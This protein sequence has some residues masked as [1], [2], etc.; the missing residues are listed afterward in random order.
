MGFSFYRPVSVDS[1]VARCNHTDFVVCFRFTLSYL[2]TVANGGSVQNASGYDIVFATDSAG[3]SILPFDRDYYDPSTGECVFWIKLPTTDQVFYLCYGNSGISA[4]QQNKATCWSDYL[5]V[6]HLSDGT[7]LSGSDAVSASHDLTNH[8]ALA[9]TGLNDGGANFPS[10]ADA[11]MESSS[12][13]FNDLTVNAPVTFSFWFKSP[14]TS[15]PSS[16]TILTVNDG[17]TDAGKGFQIY[18]NG[19][20]LGFEVLSP[21][22]GS[23]TVGYWYIPL[24]DTNWHHVSITYTG[25]VAGLVTPGSARI[26]LD[27]RPL[28]T[29][30]AFAYGG[31]QVSDAGYA[32]QF[33]GDPNY[34]GASG[35]LDAIIDEL[36][37]RQFD[38]DAEWALDHYNSGNDP[39]TFL[40]IG[41][42]NG[43][44]PS[45]PTLLDVRSVIPAIG[46]HGYGSYSA[47]H[48]LTFE[49]SNGDVFRL[50]FD[51]GASLRYKIVKLS[52]SRWIEMDGAYNTDQGPN[53]SVVMVSDKLY[54][55]S[56]KSSGSTLY[57]DVFDTTAETFDSK[58]NNSGITVTPFPNFPSSSYKTQSGSQLGKSIYEVAADSSG[59][60]HLT[61]VLF[62]TVN[63]QVFSRIWYTKYDHST[64]STPIELSG[65]SGAY[66]YWPQQMIEAGGTMRLFFLR[67]GWTAGSPTQYNGGYT[68]I[69]AGGAPLDSFRLQASSPGWTAGQFSSYPASSVALVTSGT[70]ANTYSRITAN[71]TDYV[72]T[73]GFFDH[74]DGTTQFQ[75]WE[76][77]NVNRTPLTE[78]ALCHTSISGG[79]GNGVQV[80]ATDLSSLPFETQGNTNSGNPI[81]ATFDGEQKMAITYAAIPSGETDPAYKDSLT[82]APP[83]DA[84][85][86]N[87]L[88]PAVNK[89]AIGTLDAMPT[90][91]VASFD[92]TIRPPYGWYP[93]E[94]RAALVDNNGTIEIYFCGT[95]DF[96][97]TLGSPTYPFPDTT[98][99][100]KVAY[101]G[102]GVWSDPET[103]LTFTGHWSLASSTSGFGYPLLSGVEATYLASGDILLV[104]YMGT[105]DGAG[106]TLAFGHHES[107]TVSSIIY[108]AIYAA[109]MAGRGSYN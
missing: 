72:D 92:E 17:Y 9:A 109:R 68:N 6:Y 55:F 83:W 37:I 93:V 99:L 41:S 51:D 76:N 74:L 101:Q 53:W 20:Y 29:T 86:A 43:S 40:V 81:V 49:N 28:E 96:D 16:T 4:D 90:W 88:M 61:F 85:S 34:T 73:D 15:R 56:N 13:D 3:S 38:P 102:S 22:S 87:S 100:H 64:W 89:V 48:P 60:I 52:G 12:T 98:M 31:P 1:S 57:F 63:F 5:A 104:I 77:C 84:F 19:G 67:I 103:L 54:I 25:T 32:L 69:Y 33:G 106:T 2:K 50:V 70:G 21:G 108:G 66:D 97:N 10:T 95:A 94:N 23:P 45:A 47:T 78:V 62:Q 107:Y 8:G 24:N 79:D 105:R 26:Y 36:R 30:G 58:G 80:I 14:V 18:A 42:E 11:Y 91:T 82:Y 39:S 7:T 46:S 35:R 75:I 27:G 65:Q 71:G 59:N 44:S